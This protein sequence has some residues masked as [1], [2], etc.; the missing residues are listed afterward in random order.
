MRGLTGVKNG[1]SKSQNLSVEKTNPNKNFVIFVT[2]VGTRLLVSGR[3]PECFD[4][5]L[6]SVEQ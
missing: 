2:K 5:P 4:Y 3:S 6:R 1:Y